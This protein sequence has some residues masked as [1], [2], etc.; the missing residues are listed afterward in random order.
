MFANLGDLYGEL[1]TREHGDEPSVAFVKF[2]EHL[3]DRQLARVYQNC[4]DRFTSGDKWA[5]N[6]GLLI[7]D[8]MTPP[9][10][11]L[12]M[13]LHRILGKKPENEIERWVARNADYELRRCPVGKELNLLRGWYVKAEEL[14]MR[15]EL[16]A[17]RDEL[18]ALP[19]HSVKNLNDIK[20]EQYESSGNKHRFADRISALVKSKGNTN[21]G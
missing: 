16:N 12:R 8:S 15:G 14:A 2:A 1:W 10:S 19:V 13:V 9:E 7:A 17:E 6:L 3:N 4:R 5:P 18:L 11:E 20:R 21:N